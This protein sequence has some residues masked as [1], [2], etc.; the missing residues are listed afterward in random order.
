[1]DDLI[2]GSRSF[3]NKKDYTNSVFTKDGW[4]ESFQA[5][6]QIFKALLNSREYLQIHKYIMQ[7]CILVLEDIF[8]KV[9]LEIKTK[10]IPGLTTL[11]K[12]KYEDEPRTRITLKDIFTGN[13]TSDASTIL[14]GIVYQPLLDKYK[15]K[16]IQK[17]NDQDA[18]KTTKIVYDYVLQNIERGLFAI[19]EIKQVYE[20]SKSTIDKLKYEKMSSIWNSLMENAEIIFKNVEKEKQER[21]SAMEIQKK[22]LF[23]RRESITT[24][25]KL[26][27]FGL[28]DEEE[29]DIELTY[30]R[31]YPSYLERIAK[32]HKFKF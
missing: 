19:P 14:W 10:E 30:N 15:N 32:K 20:S 8:G 18:N 23:T 2:S 27:K 13:V 3:F 29:E 12:R 5:N 21:K 9:D 7:N 22:E 1:M 11:G 28:E 16:L 17:I 31:K 4:S 24:M 6:K 25:K 26:R